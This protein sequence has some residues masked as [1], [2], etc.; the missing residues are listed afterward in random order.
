M[1]EREELLLK[2]A[3]R[4]AEAQ[5]ELQR[6]DTAASAAKTKAENSRLERDR[7]EK[8]LK[9]F[10]GRNQ[11]RRVVLVDERDVVLIQMGEGEAVYISLER[12]VI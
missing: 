10:V 5:R 9:E 2:T 7:I 1:T 8:E 12:A 3:Q 6:S 11:R 4:Y